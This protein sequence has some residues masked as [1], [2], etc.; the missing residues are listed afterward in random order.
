MVGQAGRESFVV[1]VDEKGNAAVTA[2]ASLLQYGLE[3]TTI[4]AV[5][6]WKFRPATKNGKEVGIRMLMSIDYR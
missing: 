6:G 4:E 5:R 2:F 1:Y 3:E